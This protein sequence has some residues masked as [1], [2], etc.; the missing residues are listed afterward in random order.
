[1]IPVVFGVT[2]VCFFMLRLLPGDPADLL[3]G[4][5][6]T[7]EAIIALQ[8]QLGLDRP[9]YKQYLS[10]LN[11]LIH[12]SLGRSI[13]YDQPVTALILERLPATLYLVIY[14]TVLAIIVT[15]PL[16]TLAALKR[17]SLIDYGIRG[18]FVIALAMPSFWLGVLLILLFSIKFG[19]FP[20]SGYGDSF[21][22]RLWHLFLP[23]FTIGLATASITIRS[24]RSTILSVLTAD[25]IDTAKAKGIKRKNILVRHVLRNA[26]ISTVS[27]LGVHTS[28]VIGGTVVI[29]SVFSVP[30]LGYLLVNSIYSRDYPIVQGL[31]IVFAML[32]IVINLLTDISYSIIDPRVTYD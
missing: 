4:S 12:G 9:I 20:V 16:A 32:V 18:S 27:I 31:T 30:G 5:R 28:W 29:E 7:P 24:L 8:E 14:S 10:F 13:F 17:D 21:F 11:D 26:L 2:L 22:S 15:V 23:A 3:L 1:M 25:Y 6:A 19:L